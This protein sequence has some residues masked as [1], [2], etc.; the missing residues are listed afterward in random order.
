M[1]DDPLPEPPTVK[2]DAIRDKLIEDLY[3]KQL[4]IAQIEHVT[5]ADTALTLEHAREDTDKAI[6]VARENTKQALQNTRQDTDKA[7]EV[8]RENTKQALQNT[9]QD[10]DKAVEVAR[11]NTELALQNSRQDTDKAVENAR[12]DADRAAETALLKSIHDGYITII[13]GT[14]DRSVTRAQFLTATI[15]AIAT[16]YTAVLG[17]NYA[18]GSGKPAP[19]RAIIPVLALGVAFVLASIYVAYLSPKARRRRLLPSAVGGTATA[20]RRLV[21][22]MEWTF[23]GVLD[24][25]WALR[26][27]VVAFAIG[28]ALLPLPFLEITGSGEVLLVLLV[29]VIPTVL[30]IVSELL[31]PRPT[32][33][34]Y[35]ADPGE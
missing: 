4:E 15:G 32:S 22:L 14:L 17:V 34:A 28:I 25:A 11:E 7:I 10:T 29:C 21:T 18:V 1:S 24:R 19:G 2:T 9:R 6:E 16:T 23:A 33:D 12:I 30:W 27:S 20:E 13:Q 31:H 5:R 35:I 3:Q 26:G 8:A